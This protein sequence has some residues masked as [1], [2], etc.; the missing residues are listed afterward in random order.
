MAIFDPSKYEE[1]PREEISFF[2]PAGVYE[3]YFSELAIKETIWPDGQKEKMLGGKITFMDG[4]RAGKYFYHDFRIFQADTEKRKQACVWFGNFLRA[5]GT[6]PL[7]PEADTEKM[8]NKTFQ[9]EVEVF[10]KKKKV[11]TATG[12]EWVADETAKKSNKLVPW[13][14]HKVGGAPLPSTP[15]PSAGSSVV[16]S[17]GIRPHHDDTDDLAPF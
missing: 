6:G 10:Q 7:D 14:F 13:A 4:P 5:I 15:K 16:A 2:A 3:L 17:N 9:G 8:I 11:Q 1:E 12:F